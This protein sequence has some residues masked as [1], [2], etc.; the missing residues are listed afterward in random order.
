MI[1]PK[2]PVFK[3]LAATFLATWL[4][5]AASFAVERQA[6]AGSTV[7]TIAGA[8]FL[9]GVFA[10][11][12]LALAFTDRI[13]GRGATE[14]LFGRVFRWNVGVRWYVFA[15]GFMPA[16][17][18]LA[19]LVHRVV[20]GDWPRFGQEPW[21]L[22]I[23]ALLISTWVQAGEELGWRGYALPGLAE[24]F[25]LASASIIVGLIW[26]SWHLPLFF[27]SNG[28]LLGQST[29]LYLLQVTALSV[30]MAWLYWR[31]NGSLLLVMLVHAA[32]NN[33]KDIVPSAATGATNPLTFNASLVG[34]LTVAILWI[35]AAY[36]LFQ[37]R[38]VT[39]LAKLDHASDV[40]PRFPVRK[41]HLR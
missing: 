7:V 41:E 24:R 39:A 9:L 38:G 13:E 37:M 30:V 3:Y 34:W 11:G 33:I 5:W 32:V 10:P 1:L 22:M 27:Y 25:G 18:L 8:V 28:D 21:Y 23:G 40:L 12:V 35:V 29:P 15:I 17:K 2:R 4:L 31:T 16:V 19:A 36:F 26:G 14:A 6:P 20:T